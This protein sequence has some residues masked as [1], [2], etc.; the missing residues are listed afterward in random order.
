MS[1][2]YETIILTVRKVQLNL[3]I[4]KVIFKYYLHFQKT[5]IKFRAKFYA[6]K[7]YSSKNNSLNC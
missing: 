7:Q 2:P 5:R 6:T 4:E 1:T 3:K